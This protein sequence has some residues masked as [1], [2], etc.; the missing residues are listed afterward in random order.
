MNDVI[1][2]LILEDS[3]DDADLIILR[4]KKEGYNINFQRV[5]TEAEFKS[6]LDSSIDLVIAD[7][8]LPQYTG[9]QALEDLKTIGLD[10]PFILVSGT[11]GEEIAVEAI[12]QGAA[13]Y[14]L[15]DRPMRLGAAVRNVMQERQL[16]T[17]KRKAERTTQRME[18]RL[19]ILY[20]AS[21]EIARVSLDL[22]QVFAAIHHA[23]QKLMSVEAFAITLIDDKTAENH[24]VYLI[25][26][27]ERLPEKRIPL[28]RGL[29]R[30]VSKSGKPFLVN[31][32]KV[33][34]QIDVVHFG[35]E[36]HV[37]SILAVP[38]FV[39]EKMIGML[40]AQSYQSG[41]Y[42]SEDQ[43]LLEM[44][45][46][47]AAAA[48]QNARLHAAIRE[49][50]EKY[51]LITENISD[52]I[53]LMD[54]NTHVTYMSPSLAK[55]QG[56]CSLEELNSIPLNQHITPESYNRLLH[57]SYGELTKENLAKAISQLSHPV[58]IE[59]IRKDG[60]TYWSEITFVLVRDSEGEP[61]GIIGVG[62]DITER[63]Q[64][65]KALR[66]S[67]M[68]Y[69]SLFENV[70]DGVCRTT[71]EGDIL[72]VNPALVKMLEYDSIDEL[73][74]IT[75][76][77][78]WWFDP[79]EREE[80]K[81]ELERLGELSNYEVVF[82]TKNNRKLALLNN[83]SVHRNEEGKIVYYQGT[84]T[85]ITERI[86][87]QRELEALN[88]V[89]EGLRTANAASEILPVILNEIMSVVDAHGVAI[90]T[91]DEYTDD[92]LIKSKSDSEGEIQ[93]IHMR[94]GEGITGKVFETGKLYINDDVSKD[95]DLFIKDF[96]QPMAGV[97][98]PL[99]T[100]G[101][102]IHALWVFRDYKFEADELRILEAIADM[103]ANALQR[104]SLFEKTA[105]QLR[106]LTSLQAIDHAITGSMDLNVT[107][108]ILLDQV[109]TQLNIHSAAVLLFNS[110]SQTLEYSAS[111]GFTTENLKKY[112]AR[113]GGGLASQAVT[114]LEIITCEMGGC[115]DYP[116]LSETGYVTQIAVPLIAKGQVK[117]VLELFHRD[118]LVTTPE[119]RNFF[120]TLASTA[121]ISI[122]NATLFADVQRANI[123][124]SMAYDAT[125]EG[126]SRAL[127]L[128]DQ[129][130]EGHTQRVVQMTL[131]LAN[132]LGITGKELIHIRRGA[133]LHDIGKMAIP[134]S[135]LLKPGPLTDEEWV[136]MRQHPV[137]AY[138]LL[139]PIP[140]LRQALD[141][142]HCHHEKWDGTGYPRNL[143]GTQI[144][145]SARIFA[146]VDVYDALTSD[147]PYRAAW[148]KEEALA[149]IRKNIGTHFEPK[150]VDAFNKFISTNGN[151]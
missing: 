5:E 69:R 103:A 123:E 135:I 151:Y 125:I 109:I 54:M 20:Q 146:V 36:E 98:I 145:L 127:D 1:H 8:S 128:R 67:E 73:M 46:T 16:R 94:F 142:P 32:Y 24:A 129:E 43:T 137:Y 106:Q 99:S 92:I 75:N 51:R 53:W 49:S 148:S 136:V 124:L 131:E 107:L 61:D 150:V 64:A 88:I 100:S 143:K 116:F 22:E 80:W 15:K 63:K 4:L 52:T 147:R 9:L 115:P 13:D 37:K 118:N 122:D 11:M 23:A 21:Q 58:E 19:K 77:L 126:W 10:I 105:L 60:T 120:E 76:A 18:T 44:L 108:N 38:M 45:S 27:G 121:A 2:L 40:S 134:D 39:G 30:Y 95:P 3:Q 104:A 93:D 79:G 82:K 141:I 26:K 34:D 47:H 28:N 83:V 90:A 7:Y 66:E 117:G 71:P 97:C 102:L 113:R 114:R 110:I 42:S 144:P 84:L 70:L 86:Q 17:D 149:Y 132:D 72:T 78:D 14:L 55:A 111:K 41:A 112:R 85:D 57:I 35:T 91:L 140:Y 74:T 87:R 81:S 56:Y 65:E 96:V 25:D 139:H 119:W 12:K 29:T 133:L 101:K 62:R 130:T 6:A 68:K 89:G 33:D 59:F 50:E 31:D 138:Q 48:I